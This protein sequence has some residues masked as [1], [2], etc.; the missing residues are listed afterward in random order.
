MIPV[1]SQHERIRLENDER[2]LAACGTP[3]FL[4]CREIA[5]RVGIST[6]QASMYLGRLHRKLLLEA[7]TRVQADHKR[8]FAYRKRRHGEVGLTQRSAKPPSTGSNPVGAS[9][10]S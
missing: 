10:V 6:Q 5:K 4:S 8:V 3:E 2:I 9:V 1:L 7:E